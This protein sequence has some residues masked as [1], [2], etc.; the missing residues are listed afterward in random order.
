MERSHDHT[1][2]KVALKDHHGE[3]A[4]EDILF[5][6]PEDPFGMDRSYLF[7]S[8]CSYKHECNELQ[9]SVNF[10]SPAEGGSPHDALFFVLDYLTIQ[11]LLSIEGVCRSLRDA[12][13]GDP[14]LWRSIR[15]AEP[16][17][18]KITDKALVQLIS[19]AQGTLGRLIL[20]NCPNITDNGLRPVVETNPKLSEVSIITYKF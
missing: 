14:Y 17:N 9:I 11:D 5:Q 3:M 10:N 6:L 7:Q 8:G 20:V 13:R 1:V 12:V 15:I 19:R 16:L 18:V 4:N 2:N